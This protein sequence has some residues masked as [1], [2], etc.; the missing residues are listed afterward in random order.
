[1]Y[2]THNC[3]LSHVCWKYLPELFHMLWSPGV[4]FEI[5]AMISEIVTSRIFFDYAIS[6]AFNIEL[7]PALQIQKNLEK[8]KSLPE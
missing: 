6:S 1:M 5:I 8:K 2:C 3:G 7:F 4:V